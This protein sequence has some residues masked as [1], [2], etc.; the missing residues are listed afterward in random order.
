MA[1]FMP[2]TRSERRMRA[3][4]AVS[5]GITGERVFRGDLMW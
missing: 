1:D 4:V 3:A 5:A 2:R